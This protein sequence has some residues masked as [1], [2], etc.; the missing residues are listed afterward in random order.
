MKDLIYPIG[1]IAEQ[2]CEDHH[3]P[4]LTGLCHLALNPGIRRLE[5]ALQ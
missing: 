5:S 1:V 4:I 3:L 2:S